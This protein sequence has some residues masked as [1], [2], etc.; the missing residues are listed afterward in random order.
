MTPKCLEWEELMQMEDTFR[1]DGKSKTCC[2]S[3]TNKCL[4]CSEVA[5]VVKEHNLRRHSDTKHGA[6]CAKVPQKTIIREIKVKLRSQLNVLRKVT[7]KDSGSESIFIVAE[8]IPA[9]SN[10]AC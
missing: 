4:L 3:R 1:K 2:A 8:E 10:S 6:K 7:T 9:A 5:S